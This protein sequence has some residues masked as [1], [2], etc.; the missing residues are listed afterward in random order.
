MAWHKRLLNLLH[1]RR[2]SRDIDR[3]LA[4]HIAER[5]DEL[6]AAGMSEAEAAREAQRRFGNYGVQ[7]ERTRDNDVLGWLESLI[8]DLRYALRSLRASP[9]FAL[10]AILSLALG[11]GAN[12][13]IFSL[14][15]A[16]MLK[17]LPVSHPEQ[18]VMM[19]RGEHAS[20][21][22]G[23]GILGS[24]IFTNPLWEQIRDRQD[25][26]SGVFAVGDD[27]FNLSTS[28]EA[29]RVLGN[30]VSGDFFSTLGVR[31][32]VGRT[33]TRSDDTHGCPS[34]AVLSYGFWQSTYGGDPNVIGKTISLESH[35]F[36][37]IGVAAEGF[38]GVEVGRSVQV[39]TPL[40][41]IELM[42]GAGYL[43]K[44]S[45]WYLHVIGRPKPG[46][47][48]QRVNA[49]LQTIAPAIYEATVPQD[50]SVA[51]QDRYRQSGLAASPMATG[52]S[53]LRRQ[54]RG[55]LLALMAMVGI[56]LLIACANVANLLLARA[57]VRQRE[58]AVR[59]AVGAGRWR[60]I[61]QLLTESTLL[62]LC[63]A[64]LGALFAIWSA[65]ALVGLLSTVGDHASLDVAIDLRVLGFTI[66]VALLTGLLFGLAPAW[67][68]ARVE[69]QTVMKSGGRSV[70]E[71]RSHFRLGK[72]LVITQVALSLVLLTG[73]GLMVG[74]FRSLAP[75]DPG[76]QRNQVLLAAVDLRN[77][78]YSAER[79]RQFAHDMVARLRAM[80][81]VRAASASWMMPISGMTWN[82]FIIVDGFSPK[83]DD[84]RLVDFN[85]VS[86]GFF[87]TL[88]TP[89][90]AGRDFN[91][92]DTPGSPQV[93]IVN[94][95]LARK[96]F[97]NAN[98]LGKQFRVP[99]G[100]KVGPPIE[101]VGV[102]GD[103]KY[104]SLRETAPPTAYLAFT[105]QTDLPTFMSFE[106]RTAGAPTALIPS[107]TSAV[108]E[109]SSAI[110]RKSVV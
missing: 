80:P 60:L 67:R 48:E 28:G 74:T 81:G 84:G 10:V 100:N 61:R 14:I 46:L 12:T 86:D 108:G 75:L 52:F 51:Q 16:V 79:Q 29:H 95:A 58:I 15:D 17:Y 107:V 31:P 64:V 11:I 71:G 106:L 3:E 34:V 8:A 69:P 104:E 101:V 65:R 6:V 57:T 98:P 49:R 24:P 5:T 25:V 2:L 105:Q 33:I 91:T 21:T 38:F 22:I 85:A 7:K 35:P 36:Q 37:I 66:A 18:L 45:T 9:G 68:S 56:V 88:G 99:A 62:S 59:L 54:Y 109:V 42:H 43:N 50:W 39:Y 27:Q 110:D 4:F 19:T 47:T 44:R 83:S 96:F 23:R 32:V 102:V 13:A 53:S 82:D 87:T 90:L 76:F 94:E 92:S 97:G 77:V 73:A 30:W 1:S 93:A 103:A 41:A 20:G 78:H 70:T 55:A 89:L 26:F 72:A 40:C 63:G